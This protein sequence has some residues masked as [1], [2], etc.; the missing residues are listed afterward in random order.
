ML[1]A[2][3]AST[4]LAGMVGGRVMPHSFFKTEIILP[5]SCIPRVLAARSRFGE[6]LIKFDSAAR[7]MSL[8]RERAAR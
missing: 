8:E 3:V 2:V 6:I 1:S 5:Y 4:A 7:K